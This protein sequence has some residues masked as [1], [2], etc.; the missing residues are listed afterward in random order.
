VRC[1]GGA[2][3]SYELVFFHP[4]IVMTMDPTTESLADLV[5][6]G[7]PQ[8]WHFLK[9]PTIG[10][11]GDEIPRGASDRR[12]GRAIARSARAQATCRGVSH[13]QGQVGV[14]M[15]WI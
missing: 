11:S 15:W 13:D 8:I 9:A 2:P 4:S 1:Q 14:K 7:A 3:N 5:N 6:Y 10:I 12:G